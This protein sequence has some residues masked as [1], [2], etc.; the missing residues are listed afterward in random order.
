MTIHKATGTQIF[1]SNQAPETFDEEGFKSLEWTEIGEVLS[2]SLDDA[3]TYTPIKLPLPIMRRGS[4]FYMVRTV[5]K[6]ATK[7]GRYTFVYLHRRMNKK[8]RSRFG[9][10][11]QYRMSAPSCI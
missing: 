2:H 11:T 3:A 10:L 9:R 4:Y 8:K 5:R 1:I 6:I 7:N